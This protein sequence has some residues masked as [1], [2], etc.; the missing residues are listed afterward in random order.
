MQALRKFKKALFHGIGFSLALFPMA[1]WAGPTVTILGESTTNPSPGTTMYVTISICDDLN[2]SNANDIQAPITRRDCLRVQR[3][4]LGF[5]LRHGRPIYGGGRGYLG[6]HCL[7]PGNVRPDSQR[8]WRGWAQ[9]LSHL[10]GA[11]L[12]RLPRQRNSN[13]DLAHLY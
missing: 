8:G 3:N 7:W 1:V 11:G 12:R 9:C 10:F 13:G 5:Q 6:E 2:Y 4:L